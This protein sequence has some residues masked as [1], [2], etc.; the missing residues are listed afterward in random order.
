MGE[1]PNQDKADQAVQTK[2][3]E[4]DHPA[5]VA[6]PPIIYV[7]SMVAGLVLHYFWP[8]SIFPNSIGVWLGGLMMVLSFSVLALSLREFHR[9]KTPI[10][11]HRP[12]ATII[13]TGPFRYSRNPVYLSLTGLQIGIAFIA[14]STWVLALLVPTLMMI[15][16]GVILREERYL[17]R[18]FG[19]E[20]TNYRALVRRWF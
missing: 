11:P 16:S 15:Y 12:T 5:L 20:Y 13:R 6:P 18:K 3:L 8:M 7:L 4:P 19:A 10:N 14:D 9:W 17:E 1:K 2:R